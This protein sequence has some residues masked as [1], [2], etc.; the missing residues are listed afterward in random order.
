MMEKLTFLE[1][2][3]KVLREEIGHCLHPKSGK[4]QLP[5]GTNSAL[6]SRG[7]TPE[8]TLYSAIFTDARDNP[9]SGFVKIGARPARYFLKGLAEQKGPPNLRGR[10]LPPKR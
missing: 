1:L 10:L 3:K 2:A 5:R 8:A 7:K 6:Q 9:N 4:W